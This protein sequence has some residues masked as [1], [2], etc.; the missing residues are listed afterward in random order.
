MEFAF[1]LPINGVSFG[2]VSMGFLREAHKR[3]LNPNI[4]PVNPQNID[5]STQTISEDFKSWIEE[6]I[7][8]SLE[9][10]KKSTPVFK[11]WHLNGSME[12]VSEKQLLF[13]FYELDQPTKSEINIAKNCSRVLVSSNYAKSVFENN[14]LDN[15]SF[16]PLYFDADNF[17][18]KD[19]QYFADDRI[20]FN[21][22]G[23]FLLQRIQFSEKLLEQ[24]KEDY[25]E[26]PEEQ[27]DADFVIMT[28]A[29]T[30]LISTLLSLFLEKPEKTKQAQKSMIESVTYPF[31]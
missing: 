15:V 26:K 2:Q 30:T 10:H 8:K 29:L 28:D 25:I 12:S 24:S 22:T 1:H 5:L 18:R 23:D 21:F 19:K 16:V 27:L 31:K 4:F 9:T 6:R 3:N 11:L 7:G 14:G 13:T 20:T 17:K